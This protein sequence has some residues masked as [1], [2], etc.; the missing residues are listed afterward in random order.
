MPWSSNGPYSGFLFHCYSRDEYPGPPA[1]TLGSNGSDLIHVLLSR[2]DLWT[3]GMA[4][5]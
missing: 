1:V 3:I 2:L 4:L 5:G